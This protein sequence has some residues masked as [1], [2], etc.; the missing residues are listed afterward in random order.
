MQRWEQL[1][2]N[3]G[4]LGEAL[5]AGWQPHNAGWRYPVFDK[6]GQQARITLEGVEHPVFRWKAFDSNAVPK[7]Q[8]EPSGMGKLRPAYYLLPGTLEVIEKGFGE[9]ILAS[10]EPD[11]LAYRSAGAKN[12]LC[13]FGENATPESLAIDLMNMGVRIIECYP[14]RDNA[15]LTWARDIVTRLAGS[16]I[17]YR[18]YEL[19]GALGSKLDINQV[20]IDCQFDM[21]CFWDVLIRCSELD[22]QPEPKQSKLPSAQSSDELPVEFYSAIERALGVE[23]YKGNGFSEPIRCP[24]HDDQHPSAAW[25]REKHILK[26]FVCNKT[27]DDFFLAKDVAEKLNIDYRSFLPQKPVAVKPAPSAPRPKPAGQPQIVMSWEQATAKLLAQLNGEAP[28]FEPLPMPFRAIASKGGFAKRISPGKLIAVV[29]DSGMGKTSLVETLI[30]AWRKA[31]F[32]GVMWGPEWSYEQYVQRAI[33]RHGGPSFEA[34]EDHKAHLSEESRN[35][36]L[37]KRTGVP[38]SPG[39]SEAICKITTVLNN[40]PGKLHFV[41]RMGLPVEAVIKHMADTVASYAA[42]GKRIAFAVLDYVQLMNAAGDSEIARVKRVLDAFKWFCVD[43]QLVGVIGSQMTKM[44]GRAAASGT[45]GGQHS[46]VYARSDTFNLALVITRPVQPDGE[47]SKIA[48]C[49]IVKNSTG[50]TGDV[51]LY[52]NTERLSWHDIAQPARAVNQ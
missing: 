1:L 33:Q 47:L 2:A 18:V 22:I 48:N 13:W 23:K 32:H 44:D 9:C 41:E 31:G 45:K 4:I 5:A 3:R 7:Y 51:S 40:W 35:V 38:L 16:G 43:R 49:R 52:L 21:A 37:P 15:G 8:W 14:D 6:S 50:R 26:C 11:V 17:K 19:P 30:D 12:V 36:P 20:W 27:N 46:M 25:H 42:N 24:F 34:V 29:G 39:Q 28:V 10:G